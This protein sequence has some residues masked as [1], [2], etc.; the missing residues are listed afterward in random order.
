MTGSMRRQKRTNIKV[1]GLGSWRFAVF[2]VCKFLFH[3]LVV[4]VYCSA[5]SSAHLPALPI[6]GFHCFH[7][8]PLCCCIAVRQ[9]R[10]AALSCRHRVDIIIVSFLYSS[11]PCCRNLLFGIAPEPRTHV[12]RHGSK[13]ARLA[14][15]NSNDGPD[16]SPN[17]PTRA[18]QQP[19]GCADSCKCRRL[20]A[21]LHVFVMQDA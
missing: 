5:L 3:E 1:E 14:Q 4:Y 9:W 18:T 2:S 15:T 16:P 6:W 8:E 12:P 10:E 20:V 17:A 21:A 7:C 19:A 11:S 13:R